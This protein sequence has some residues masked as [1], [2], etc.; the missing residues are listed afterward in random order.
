M[1]KIQYLLI[2]II[3]F[4]INSCSDNEIEVISFD[5]SFTPKKATPGARDTP[6]PVDLLHTYA[7][8]TNVNQTVSFSKFDEGDTVSVSGIDNLEIKVELNKKAEQE[9][10]YSLS[11]SDK[12]IKEK[13]ENILPEE[14]YTINTEPIAVGTEGNMANIMINKDV[15]KDLE[16]GIYYLP[17]E[18]KCNDKEIKTLKNHEILVVKVNVKR[19]LPSGENVEVTQ[20]AEGTIVDGDFLSFDSDYLNA[21]GNLI[22]LNDRDFF[23]RPWWVDSSTPHWLKIR[24]REMKRVSA[25][26]LQTAIADQTI[27][28][29]DVLVSDDDGVTYASQGVAE[30]TGNPRAITISFKKP[31]NINA[32]KLDNFVGTSRWINIFEVQLKIID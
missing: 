30:T 6:P 23:G 12:W 14:V 15:I 3:P 1:K 26:V 29:V 25:I 21:R 13:S 8:F 16:D 24:M 19:G 4:V 20:N 5:N 2:L 28:T 10:P 7:F 31:L 9:I 32:I 17:I 22:K 18:L 11:L 27:R